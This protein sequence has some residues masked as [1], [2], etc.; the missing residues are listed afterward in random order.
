MDKGFLIKEF[1]EKLGVTD[2][3]VINWEVRRRMPTRKHIQK[4]IDLPPN[5]AKFFEI[6]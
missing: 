1:A 5:L 3:T 2:D 6:G 4:V